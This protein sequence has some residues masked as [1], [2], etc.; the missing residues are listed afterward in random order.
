MNFIS[1][2]I[3]DITLMFALRGWYC[4]Q[5][6]EYLLWILTLN[7]Q[8]KQY[9]KTKNMKKDF[10]PFTNRKWSLSPYSVKCSDGTIVSTKGK[11]SFPCK[12]ICLYKGEKMFSPYFVNFS[13]KKHKR[14]GNF[15]WLSLLVSFRLLHRNELELGMGK[16][17]AFVALPLRVG[18]SHP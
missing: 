1:R 3:P 6:W 10:F 13:S 17:P 14:Y 2:K 7:I 5:C 11:R 9:E 12:N 8:W 15:Y 18:K 16:F 4:E